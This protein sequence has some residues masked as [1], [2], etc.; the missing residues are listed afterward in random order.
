M[1]VHGAKGLEAPVVVLIDGCDVGGRDPALLPL[2]EALP[3][4]A[5]G[6]TS[7]P[8]IVAAARTRV[9]QRG[10]EEH[11]RLLYVAMTRAKDRLVIAP[12]SSKA[13]TAAEAWCQMIRAG[14][15]HRQLA[16]VHETAPY[17]PVE[18][19]RDGAAGAAPAQG[20]GEEEAAVAIPDWLVEPADPEP[21]DPPPLR[22]SGALAAADRPARPADG[23]FAAQARLRG[24]LV[25]ALI[26]RLPEVAPERRGDAAAAFLRARAPRLPAGEREAIAASALR[27]LD[28][29]D[30]AGAFGPGSRAEVPIAGRVR[31]PGMGEAAPVSGQIDRLVVTPDEVLVLDFKTS[32]KAPAP[33]AKPRG[34]YVL[35][36]ALYRAL[37]AEIY[38]GRRV[39]AFLV[40]TAGPLVQEL[41]GAAMDEALAAVTPA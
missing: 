1:T 17:G 28:H 36:L 33:D 15:A 8:G 13:D 20:S 21:E 11:N 23:P 24:A 22:P 19:F 29:P 39:R 30:L 41:D 26:E 38:P 27:V 14:F 4:W 35:Q 18:R 16:L 32:A 10:L 5:P 37:L 25:H 6:K 40:W 7:D 31:L 12:Y 3:V 2:G 9:Q 34:S